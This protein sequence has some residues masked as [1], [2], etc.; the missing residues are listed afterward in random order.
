MTTALSRVKLPTV[1]LQ[2]A[3]PCPPGALKSLTQGVYSLDIAEKSRFSPTKSRPATIAYTRCYDFVTIGRKREA[4][5]FR[6]STEG[7]LATG[8]GTDRSNSKPEGDWR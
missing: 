4:A 1:K 8:P 7:A 3:C 6:F 2:T 5:G